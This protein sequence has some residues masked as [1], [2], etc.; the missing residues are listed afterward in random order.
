[1]DEKFESFEAIL[2]ELEKTVS[3]LEG[4][5]SL[6]VALALFEK[7]MNLSQDCEAYLL[8]AR[9]KMEQLKK[10]ANGETRTELFRPEPAVME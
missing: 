10:R 6:D 8:A 1:M 5:V 4:N 7:G 3:E 9:Q 2:E